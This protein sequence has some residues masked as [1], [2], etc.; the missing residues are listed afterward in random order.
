MENKKPQVKCYKKSQYDV[1]Y[2]EPVQSSLIVMRVRDIIPKYK[3][4]ISRL[5]H[6]KLCHS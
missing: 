2:L 1:I 5:G 6:K 3:P 4:I